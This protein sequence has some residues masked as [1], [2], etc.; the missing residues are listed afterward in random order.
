MGNP[1]QATSHLSNAL[2][3]AIAAAAPRCLQRIQAMNRLWLSPYQ[4]YP[5]VRRF[6]EEL[7]ALPAPNWAPPP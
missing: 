7:A 5:I 1:D 6:N 3:L 4:D 2:S